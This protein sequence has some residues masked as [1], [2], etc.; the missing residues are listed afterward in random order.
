M[1]NQPSKDEDC[2][3]QVLESKR[4]MHIQWTSEKIQMFHEM[5]QSFTIPL[6]EL[7]VD[8]CTFQGNACVTLLKILSKQREFRSLRLCS[9]SIPMDQLEAVSKAFPLGRLDRL[10]ILSLW[11]DSPDYPESVFASLVCIPKSL[12]FYMLDFNHVDCGKVLRGVRHGFNTAK[13]PCA[14]NVSLTV[15]IRLSE[16][17]DILID[18]ICITNVLTSLRIQSLRRVDVNRLFLGIASILKRA[19]RL[20]HL[21]I[22]MSFCHRRWSQ[23]AEDSAIDALRE[24]LS[25]NSTLE[26]LMLK[27]FSGCSLI[28]NGLVPAL[29]ANS[30]LIDLRLMFYTMAEVEAFLDGLPRMKGLRHLMVITSWIPLS[31]EAW[32]KALYDNTSLQ[33]I[34]FFHN[35]RQVEPASDIVIKNILRRNQLLEEVKAFTVSFGQQY[36]RTVHQTARNIALMDVLA[37]LGGGE[38]SPVVTDMA[39]YHVVRNAVTMLLSTS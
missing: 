7:E 22:S 5:C 1:G 33:T 14:Q 39:L 10:C 27:I 26:L 35:G 32:C 31:T 36:G 13:G 16:Q 2:L 12:I 15:D 18:D 24:S 30:T 4:A 37:H 21:T 6:N 17:L 3:L 23:L 38:E 8:H 20:V 11:H 19:D 28:R 25:K 29:I 34:R 9:D